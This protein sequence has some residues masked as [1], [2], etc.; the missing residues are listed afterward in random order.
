[1]L[2]AMQE[3]SAAKGL[4]TIVARITSD[5]TVSIQMHERAG[6]EH[7]GVMREVGRKFGKLLDVCIMQ[8]MVSKH[9]S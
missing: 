4:R 5:N 6:F 2:A 3:L 1:M 7:V 8:Y 9:E